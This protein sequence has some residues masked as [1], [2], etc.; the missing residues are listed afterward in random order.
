[1]VVFKATS[2]NTLFQRMS[3]VS[4]LRFIS[5][6]DAWISRYIRS[7]AFILWESGGRDRCS[8]S[9]LAL[10]QVASESS[11]CDG[12][13]EII[14]LPP[15]FMPRS[16]SITCSNRLHIFPSLQVAGKPSDALGC[17]KVETTRGSLKKWK[18]ALF[19][20][21]LKSFVVRSSL[22]LSTS[23]ELSLA[24]EDPLPIFDNSWN[25]CSKSK[26]AK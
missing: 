23:S 13:P 9:L 17:D 5:L 2:Q 14:A 3:R 20:A 21:S 18:V 6:C 10:P 25:H 1:M 16:L 26:R 12:M 19:W 7:A 15:T 24:L 22:C 11:K 8:C 4:T